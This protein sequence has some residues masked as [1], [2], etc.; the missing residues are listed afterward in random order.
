MEHVVLKV[1]LL[2]QHLGVEDIF[3]IHVH[4]HHVVQP[5]HV[6]RHKVLDRVDFMI[7]KILH[8]VDITGKTAH[9]I[10]NRHDIGFKLVDKIIQRIER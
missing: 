10:I 5:L 2:K 6:L 1:E 8:A 9:A 7:N 3:L 4:I